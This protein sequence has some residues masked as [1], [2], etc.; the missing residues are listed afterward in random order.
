MPGNGLRTAA[1]RRLR[2]RPVLRGALRLL[3]LRDL[4]RPD[5][6][7]R[8]LRRRVRARPR[9][10][11]AAGAVP[12]R[13][14]CSSVAARRRCFPPTAS[15][16]SS[17]RSGGPPAPRS[18][19]SATRTPSTSRSSRATA[20]PVSRA[21]PSVCSPCA[22]PCSR[23]SAGRT[24]RRT[25]RGPWPR[26]AVAGFETFNLDLIY[27]ADGETLDDWR[28]TLDAVLDLDPPH[29]S[30][31]APDRRTGD[32]ARAS[33]RGRSCAARRRRP[34]DQV[35]ARRREARG[36]RVLVVRA[37]ELGAAGP[38]VPAQPPVLVPGRLPRD[39]LR[40][41]RSHHGARR[42]GAALVERADA[43]ALHRRR[44]GR[45]VAR[46]RGGAARTPRPGPRSA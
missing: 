9:V 17:A 18:P 1:L 27:G 10:A 7:R 2:P 34:G 23:R 35:R 19:S 30:A 42:F 3:R 16:A 24:I 41:P 20:P 28:A 6:P 26:P 14:V 36:G 11:R 12:S 44:D 22:F 29:V 39:R 38:R 21:S 4:D 43:G 15:R 32:P 31:Y 5:A 46:G 37:L 40:G 45:L 25:S 33:R 8:R 13:P